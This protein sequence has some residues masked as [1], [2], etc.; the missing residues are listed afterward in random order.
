VA[1][2]D[3]AGASNGGTEVATAA[4]D[5]VRRR[6]QQHILSRTTWNTSILKAPTPHSRQCHAADNPLP[7]LTSEDPLNLWVCRC[8]PSRY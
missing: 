8:V 5:E 2:F 1:Y 3:T 7:M 6:I 4:L